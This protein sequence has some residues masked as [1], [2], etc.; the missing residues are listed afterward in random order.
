[1]QKIKILQHPL[2]GKTAYFG[3]CPPKIGFFRGLGGVSKKFFSLESS[4]FCELGPPC[5]KI[6]S[7]DTP[8]CHFSN[9]GNN[10]KRKKKNTKNS[11]LRLFRRNRLHSAART[12]IMP[13]IMVTPSA[14]RRSDQFVMLQIVTA[15]LNLNSS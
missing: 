4:Y 2:L 5:K 10:K 13:S 11:G 1:M 15:Q 9:G 12:K 6:K 8:L 3:F 14:Q 7:Y